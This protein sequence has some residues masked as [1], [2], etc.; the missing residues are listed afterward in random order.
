ML[1]DDDTE[2]EYLGQNLHNIHQAYFDQY[3]KD[4]AAARGGRVAGLRPDSGRRLT[5]D[6]LDNIPDAAAIMA[7]MKAKVLANLHL[8]FSGVVPLGVD[9]QS[10]DIA[11]WA[12]SFGATVS[13]NISRR[14]THVIASP[15]RRTAKVRQAVKRG[16]RIAIVNQNWLYACFSQWRRVEVDP[17]RIHSE[18]PA[19]GTGPALPDSF[20]TKEA[21]LLSSSDEEAAQTEEETDGNETGINT[22]NGV[23]DG[24]DGLTLNT[25]V[26]DLEKYKPTVQRE[27][28]SPTDKEE[29]EDWGVIND[30]LDEFLGSDTDGASDT[31]SVRS[32]F[33]GL[34][35][36][37]PK[38]PP[39]QRKRK[40]NALVSDDGD[41]APVDADGEEGSRLQKRKKEAL[42]RTT[43]LTNMASAPTPVVG[44]AEQT[45]VDPGGGSTE[46]GPDDA[47]EEEVGDDD[48]EAQLTAELEHDE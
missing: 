46:V 10:H 13:E 27:D 11:V 7:R 5:V 47:E 16:G 6:D 2:L 23:K 15:E 41:R 18:A 38:T 8:V 26:E 4:N 9:V 25:D 31:E 35:D 44:T 40:R 20:E 17:Y 45:A 21:A 3:A 30:E 28:S 42:S 32:E 48:L 34:G 22:P 1:Q 33:T 14:T 43:S 36:D 12:R 39:S 29:V 24:P 37:V 19:N